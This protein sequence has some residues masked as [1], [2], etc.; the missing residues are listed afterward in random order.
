MDTILKINEIIVSFN[1]KIY[2]V[3]TNNNG[4]IGCCFRKYSDCEAALNHMF[5]KPGDLYKTCSDFIG[6]NEINRA[7]FIELKR[8]I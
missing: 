5:R 1:N 7:S 6:G 8:G 4:C 3:K 2:Q